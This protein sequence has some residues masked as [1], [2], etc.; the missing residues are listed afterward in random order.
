MT[1]NKAKKLTIGMLVHDDY[2]G[3]YFTIQSIRM[4][5]PEILKDIEFVIIDNNPASRAGQALAQL[6]K[7]IAEPIRYIPFTEYKSTA[8]RTKIFE[9]AKTEYV[10]C[11]DCHV[12]FTLKSLK[13][14]IDFFDAG[15]DN[16]NLLQG[17]LLYDDLKSLSTH[18]NLVWRSHMWGV[19]GSDERGNNINNEPFEI[20]AMGL[21]VFACRKSAWLGFNPLFRGF[22]G[23][24][25][26]IHEKYR[27]AGRKTLCLPFLRWIH[28]FSRPNGVPYPLR[29]EDK[30]RNY[31]IGF[32]ELGLDTNQIK[33]HFVET[34]P[35]DKYNALFE[36]TM[37]E[38]KA[39][40]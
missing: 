18:F 24:E 20:P 10:I 1:V 17:P 9:Y 22:G 33:N 19:W 16:N 4:F 11:V 34:Y 38:L 3:A 39:I 30:I 21:G 29:I 27:K 36:K 14:L 2:D 35:V 25:G 26:Y 6:I 7:W 40:N 15:K 37:Q 28:R 32:T 13:Q 31:I 23:E 12:M 8:L 5:N